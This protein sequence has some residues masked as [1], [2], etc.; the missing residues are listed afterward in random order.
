MIY[1]IETP[2]RT[3]RLLAVRRV[4]LP[5]ILWVFG[6]STTL[7]LVGLWGRAV[8]VDQDVITRS[9]EAALS[10]EIIT[11][12][13]YDWVG[14]G[15][16]AATGISA[17][18]ADGVLSEVRK[19]PDAA[20]AVDA[21]IDDV[22]AALVAP[23]DTDPEIDVAAALAPLV[24][25]VVAEL[26]ARG[27]DV[28]EATI[29]AAV[30]S[31]DPVA[32]HAGEAIPV[33]AVTEQASAMLTW[34][35][36]IA[37]AMVVLSSALA[38]AVSEER[39]SMVRSLATRIAFSALSFAVLFRIG[40][41][42]LDPDGGRSP[43]RRSGAILV[44]SNLN[45]FLVAAGLASAVAAVIWVLRRTPTGSATTILDA[46]SSDDVE[47]DDTATQELVSV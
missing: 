45:V 22:V 16:V 47:R 14:S 28:P 35:V 31:L 5:W 11:D 29:S 32:L 34:G 13:V 37:A 30:E 23:P 39:W 40:G 27:V 18:E 26:G 33:G 10:A 43:L 1:P 20:D 46:R 15:L 4:T 25:D 41:W 19:Q 7:L 6:L 3:R 42:V 8:T 17:Q 38:I 2:S 12:R 21:L 24:P 36:L 9:T 44:E